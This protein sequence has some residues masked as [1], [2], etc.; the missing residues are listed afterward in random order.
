[1][2]IYEKEYTD[3]YRYNNII[4]DKKRKNLYKELL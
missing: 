1:M 4:L 2:I 3:T